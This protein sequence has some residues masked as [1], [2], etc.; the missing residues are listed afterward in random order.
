MAKEKTVKGQLKKAGETLVNIVTAGGYGMNKALV[1]K[2][3]SKLSESKCTKKGGVW[4]KG[5]CIPKSQVRTGKSKPA[6]WY[7]EK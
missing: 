6:D 5:K 3:L 7:P 1:K 2:G 4:S